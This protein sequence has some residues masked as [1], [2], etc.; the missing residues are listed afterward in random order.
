MISAIDLGWASGFLEGEGH[1]TFNR[2]RGV[3][4]VTGTALVTA[5]QVQREPVERLARLFGGSIR[6]C[7]RKTYYLPHSGETRIGKPMNE[8]RLHGSVAIG[9]MMT[10]FP[11]M[12]PVRKAQIAKTIGLWKLAPGRRGPSLKTEC[13]YGHPLE[14]P[15]LRYE[16]GHRRCLTCYKQG[17]IK[18]R[19]R[20]ADMRKLVSR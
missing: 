8:W 16:R 20:K 10:L 17:Q 6:V 4:D 3:S 12:S 19:R 11:L 15:N 2:R 5:G 18:H 14:E 7:D 13:L 1:F 9:I